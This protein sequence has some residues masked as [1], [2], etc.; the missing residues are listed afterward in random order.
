MRKG[1]LFGLAALAA[2]AVLPPAGPAKAAEEAIE[3][4][5]LEWSFDGPFG[6]Y[7]RHALQRGLQVYREVCSVCHSLKYVAF[8]NL[9]DLG[10]TEDEIKAIAAEYIVTDGPNDD[11]DMFERPG[12][13]SDY[14][15]SPFP[16]DKAAAAANG[17]AAPPD[18]SLMAKAR[19]DGPN[20]VHALLVGYE[21]PPAEFDLAEGTNYNAYFPG[22]QIAMAQPLYEDSVAYADGTPASIDQMAADVS[23]FL[24]WAAEPK[25][26]D[27]KGTGIKVLIFLVVF[28]GVLYAVKRKVWKDVH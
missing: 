18:L 12:A 17:G 23:H 1:L 28:T 22:H 25:L 4:P 7:D 10:Y 2:T 13:P 20:Y 5:Q 15:P 24:M 3:L 26:E 16:N 6:T 27:R 19:A 8:R 9:A 21:E 11:G 14:F